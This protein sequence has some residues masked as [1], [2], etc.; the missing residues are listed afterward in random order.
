M[1]LFE[2]SRPRV[3][4]TPAGRELVRKG[5][6][7]L[8][9]TARLVEAAAQR[10]PGPCGVLPLGV[11]P[12]VAPYFLPGLL[13]RMRELF[14]RLRVVVHEMQ[15]AKLLEALDDGAVEAALLAV[16]IDLP[17][18]GEDVALEPFVLAAPP[19]HRL[20]TRAATPSRSS[21]T[22]G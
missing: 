5:R 16:P 2:R 13:A 14:T 7:L 12:T 4:I 20:A 9:L 18:G 3:L 10:E 8:Q 22:S 21:R 19:G 1:A 11:I 15:T 17:L 6:E